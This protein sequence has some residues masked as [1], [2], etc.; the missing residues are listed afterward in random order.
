[1]H[2]GPRQKGPGDN[3]IDKYVIKVP[4]YDSG[5]PEEWINFVEEVVNKCFV[6]QNISSGPQMYQLIQR[7][8]QDDAKAQFDIIIVFFL[9]HPLFALLNLKSKHATCI[10]ISN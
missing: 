9:G 3:T 1:M 5:N 8:L 4:N 6:G 7:A 2:Y 10:A